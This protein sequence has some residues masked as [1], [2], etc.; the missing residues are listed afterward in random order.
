M[1]VSADIELSRSIRRLFVRHWI[2]LGRMSVRATSGRIFLS[3]RLQRI[4]GKEP[5]LQGKTLD[6]ILYEARRIPGVKAVN[7]RLENWVNDGGHWRPAD[8]DSAQN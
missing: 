7:A 8:S 6:T 3:G 1:P 5:E 4:A 2:D